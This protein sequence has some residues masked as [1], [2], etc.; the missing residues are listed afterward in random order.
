MVEGKMGAIG[1][2]ARRVELLFGRGRFRDE[3][4]E[5]MRFHREEVEREIAAGGMSAEEARTAARR[6]FGNETRVRERSHEVIG[7]RFET[8]V[9]DLRFAVR[10]LRKNAGFTIT[11]VATLALGICASVAI[12]AVVDSALIRPLPYREPSRLVA[13]YEAITVGPQ[14]HVSYPDYVDW[15]RMNKSFEALDI[16]IPSPFMEK[17]PTGVRKVDGVAVTDGFFKTLGVTPALGRDFI[18]GEDKP[19]AP[20]TVILSYGV[21]Q[22]AYGGRTNA[23]GETVTLD[24]SI[25]TIVGVLPKG[26]HFV[27]SEPADFW[28]TTHDLN[29]SRGNHSAYGI[30]RLKP[31]VSLEQAAADMKT[32]T[33]QLEIQYPGT[34]RGRSSTVWP[35]TQVIRGDVRPVLVMLLCGAALLLLI[36]CVNVVSLLLARTENRRREIAVRGALGASRSRLTRQFVTEGL[37]LVSVGG[38]AGVAMAAAALR[39]FRELIP[40]DIVARMPYLTEMGLSGH[41]LVFAVIVVALTGAVFGVAPLLR[42]QSSLANESLND[43]GRTAAGTG[44]RRFGTKLVVVELSTAMVLLVGAGLLGKSFYRLL[45]VE[46]GMRA[47]NLATAFVTLPNV[48]YKKEEQSKQEQETTAQMHRIVERVERLPDVHSAGLVSDLPVGSGD[49]MVL[50]NV[51]G[52]PERNKERNEVVVRFVSTGYFST[53]GARL[54]QGKYFDD[55]EDTAKAHVTIINRALARKYFAG[56][57]PVGQQIQFEGLPALTISGVIDDIKEGPLEM[58]VRPAFYVP[59]VLSPD[60]GFG[61][62]VHSEQADSLLP[63]LSTTI[64]ELDP[65]IAV[66]GETTMNGKIHDSPSAA[67]HRGSAWLVGGFAATAL[68]LGVVGLYGVIAYSVSQR[69][70]EIGVRMALGAG[71]GSV[72]KMVMGEAGLLAAVGIGAGIVSSL[73]AARMMRGLLFGVSAW[74]VS[75]LVAV[76][77]VLGCAAMAASAVPA[78]RA[79]SVDPMEALRAE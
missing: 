72:M 11:A 70:R 44:W 75:T 6:R 51:V 31:G 37:L 27:P 68:V 58:E 30:A 19:S 64:H 4:D 47:E 74:D 33:G 36:A 50:M 5:E 42:M 35:L 34:N 61:L 76:A 16:Y 10:Q 46:T 13:L 25:Y 63:A 21:W 9:Q 22:R 67:M 65:G 41:V 77:M 18:T 60:R 69:T 23:L 20:K 8:V 29:S 17:T 38:T 39:A 78:R 14:F 2:L 48:P 59:F 45:H 7:F 66:Y 24:G 57:E 62:V 1:R 49:G 40:A 32:V 43:G 56:D 73:I 26:F 15:K 53:L 54:L 79:A 28:I 12:F 3:L 71:R 52:K 55:D